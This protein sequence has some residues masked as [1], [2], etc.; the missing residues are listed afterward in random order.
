[1]RIIP[2]KAGVA[3]KEVKERLILVLS[4]IKI[5]SSIFN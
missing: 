4:K 2:L 5:L 3:E 1:M